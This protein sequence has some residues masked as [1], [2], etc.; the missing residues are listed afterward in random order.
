MIA[1]LK[2]VVAVLGEGE[3]VEATLEDKAPPA[4]W[5]PRVPMP[6]HSR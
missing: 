4:L 6:Y 5:F 1:L 3:A 2:K